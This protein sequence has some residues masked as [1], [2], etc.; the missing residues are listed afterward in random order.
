MDTLCTF[1]IVCGRG[2]KKKNKCQKLESHNFIIVYFG[3]SLLI[4]T[5]GQLHMQSSSLRTTITALCPIL[6]YTLKRNVIE[7]DYLQSENRT[8]IISLKKEVFLRAPEP[9]IMFLETTM[10]RAVLET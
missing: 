1:D 4:Q 6:P 10:K 9:A 3:D 5:I 7:K 8:V 2:V